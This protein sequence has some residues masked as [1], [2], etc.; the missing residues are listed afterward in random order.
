MAAFVPDDNS[1]HEEGCL[2]TKKGYVPRITIDG[3]TY[4]RLSTNTGDSGVMYRLS[5][6]VHAPSVPGQIQ[7]IECREQGQIIFHVRPHKRV[8]LV[9]DPFAGW[10]HWPAQ[11]WS[12]TLDSVIEVPYKKVTA[13]ALVYHMKQDK[14]LVLTVCR[15]CSFFFFC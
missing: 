14:C 9:H 3:V 13:Q 10:P 12:S 2:P 1:G 4:S 6:D 5:G 8:Q 7:K 15:V 11:T